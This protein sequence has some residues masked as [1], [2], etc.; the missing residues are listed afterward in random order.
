MQTALADEFS[1]VDMAPRSRPLRCT[2]PDWVMIPPPMSPAL[3]SS[4]VNASLVANA[5]SGGRVEAA[6]R[7]VV[8]VVLLWG[9]V[10]R[11]V[12][13]ILERSVY[14]VARHYDSTV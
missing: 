3:A 6:G 7:L 12:F 11:R 1:D 2:T 4:L 14:E 13:A 10:D 5:A 9:R 8:A